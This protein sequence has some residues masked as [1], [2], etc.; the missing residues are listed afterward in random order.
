MA[1]SIDGVCLMKMARRRIGN[2][3]GTALRDL[4]KLREEATEFGRRK[5]KRLFGEDN[6]GSVEKTTDSKD[7]YQTAE[8]AAILEEVRQK[9]REEIILEKD[10]RTK[11]RRRNCSLELFGYVFDFPLR[12][13]GSLVLTAEG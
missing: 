13:I 7:R 6:L 9:N 5:I 11:R 3:I 2:Q 12:L 1:A 10:R 4:K 8:R